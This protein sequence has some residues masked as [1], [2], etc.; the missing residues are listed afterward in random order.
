MMVKIGVLGAYRGSDFAKAALDFTDAAV[1]A[2]CERDTK[3]I[4]WFKDLKFGEYTYFTDFDKMLQSDIDAVILCNYFCEHAPFAIKALKAGKHVLS[5]TLSNITMAEGVALKRAVK[6]SGKI[7]MIGENYPYM[8]ALLEMKKEYEKG[9]YGKVLYADG[10]YNHPMDAR[11]FDELSPGKYHWRSW[12]PSTYYVTHS[13]GP[14]MYV[15]QTMP[16]TVN[17]LSVFSPEQN[18]DK[19]RYAADATA[20]ILCQMDNGALFRVTGWSTF[21]EHSIWY[22][23]GCELG[24]L[25]TVRGDKESLHISSA[26]GVKTY[27]PTWENLGDFAKKAAHGG[28]DFWTLYY[29]VQ[30]IKSGEE[31]FFNVDKA[32]TMSSVAI[33][34]WRSALEK[35]VQYDIPDFNREED[36]IQ[37]ENDTLNP[38]P[39]KDGNVSIPCCIKTDYKPTKEAE[40]FAKKVWKEK[41]FQI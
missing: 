37:Y 17:A 24:G 33:L 23:L 32:V 12:L 25:E 5:E 40:E 29:F 7:Y 36:C 30:S 11:E 20:A 13:I 27:K 3:R 38:F 2:I 39:D 16:K 31:P 22:R 34:G 21:Y 8:C 10:E 4:E 15:T 35:G 6:E 1:T 9:L 14:L 19:M 41:G 28:G 18:K 26:Q